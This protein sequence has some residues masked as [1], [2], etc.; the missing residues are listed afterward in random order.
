MIYYYLFSVIA[1]WDD[2]RGGRESAIRRIGIMAEKGKVR[3]LVTPDTQPPV[4]RKAIEGATPIDWMP[5]LRK[6]ERGPQRS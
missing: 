5:S 1:M 4:I 2:V 6:E 3:N